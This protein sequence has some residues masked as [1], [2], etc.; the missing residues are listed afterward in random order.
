MKEKGLLRTKFEEVAEWWV[1]D[2]V[3][4]CKD[5]LDSMNKSKEHRFSGSGTKSS[6]ISWVD[7]MKGNK[8]V[9]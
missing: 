1:L 9:P 7:K 2:I 3:F 6:F 5:V 8:I 4:A